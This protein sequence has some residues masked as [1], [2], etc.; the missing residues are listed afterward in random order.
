MSENKT[1]ET[2]NSPHDFLKEID[3][4]E[5][6]KDARVLL[7]MMEKITGKKPIMWGPSI[8][9]FGKVHYEYASGHSG[10]ICI[11]GFSPRKQQF[12]LYLSCNLEDYKDLLDKLG[13][14]KTGKG[15]LYIRRLEDTNLKVLETLIKKTFQDATNRKQ[16]QIVD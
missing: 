2:A 9:G 1:R 7:S 4:Q 14:H 10:D 15:C 12:S 8:I 16:S 13:K 5:K 11:C 3:N 6:K